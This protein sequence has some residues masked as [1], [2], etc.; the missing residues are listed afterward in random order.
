MTQE[1]KRNHLQKCRMNKKFDKYIHTSTC[2]S[3]LNEAVGL[4]IR[5]LLL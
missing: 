5:Y 3:V 2:L 1:N 4:N